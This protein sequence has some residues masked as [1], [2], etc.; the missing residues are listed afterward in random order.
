MPATVT[1]YLPGDILF[2]I[3][4]KDTGTIVDQAIVEGISAWTASRFIHC[5]I[6][7]SALLKIE[8]LAGGVMKT[9]IDQTKVAASYLY[10]KHAHVDAANLATALLWLESQVGQ[11]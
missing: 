4:E 6:A 8:A 5:A 11:M 1:S 7:V 3:I 10:H 2:F 9:P